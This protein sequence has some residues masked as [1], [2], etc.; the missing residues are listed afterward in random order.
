MKLAFCLLV[1]ILASC[2]IA[3]IFGEGGLSGLFLGIFLGLWLADSLG[4]SNPSG[5]D[6]NE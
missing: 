2:L 4:E 1:I 6:T 3:K 5:R